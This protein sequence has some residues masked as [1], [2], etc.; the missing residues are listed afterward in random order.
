MRIK[1]ECVSY[2]VL[3]RGIYA[4]SVMRDVMLSGLFL[5]IEYVMR[6][7]KDGPKDGSNSVV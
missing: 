6:S 1:L 7:Y 3:L 5:R 4:Y 2:Y